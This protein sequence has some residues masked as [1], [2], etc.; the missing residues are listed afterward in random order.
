MTRATLAHALGLPPATPWPALLTRVR[1][2]RALHR[3][4]LAEQ[5]ARGV[6]R[7][8]REA[9]ERRERA[10]DALKQGRNGT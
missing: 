10:V 4:V 2:L 6:P 1:R 9:I 5:R 8:W 3:A 7:A